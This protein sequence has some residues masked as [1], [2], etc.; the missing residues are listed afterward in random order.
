MCSTMNNKHLLIHYNL[1]DFKHLL[2]MLNHIINI[3]F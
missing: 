3:P 1:N 2:L